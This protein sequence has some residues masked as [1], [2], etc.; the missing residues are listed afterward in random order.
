MQLALPLVGAY[1][2]TMMGLGPG[3]GWAAG[4][5]IYSAYFAP[6]MKSEGPRLDSLKVTISSFGAS[7]PKIFGTLRTG[8]NLIWSSDLVE[9]STTDDVG[10]KGGPSAEVTTYSYFGNFQVLV[11]E[12]PV[13]GIRRIW[14]NDDLI[15]DNRETSTR[16]F[17]VGGD[18]IRVYLGGNTQLADTLIEQYE[19]VGNVPAYRG[20]CTIV[21]DHLPL[22]NYGNGLPQISVEVVGFADGTAGGGSITGDIS[23]A[24]IDYGYDDY[25][26]S[27]DNYIYDTHD[28]Y[29]RK[30]DLLPRT[31]LN[32]ALLSSL[33][34]PI[35]VMSQTLAECRGSIIGSVDL[36]GTHADAPILIGTYAADPYECP[37]Q[38][39]VTV[40]VRLD[41]VT[42]QPSAVGEHTG[43]TGIKHD[44]TVAPDI[45]ETW[46]TSERFV[47]ACTGDVDAGNGLY[48]FDTISG[49]CGILW[50]FPTTDALYA[51][52]V[53]DTTAWCLTQ[54]SGAWYISR[55]TLGGAELRAAL[56]FGLALGG[57]AKNLMVADGQYLYFKTG[58]ILDASTLALV[59]TEP[60]FAGSSLF[61]LDRENYITIIDAG[62]TGDNLVYPLAGR[63]L[64]ATLVSAGATG[65]FSATERRIVAQSTTAGQ[66]VLW[67]VAG[68]PELPISF[69]NL[70][71]NI[72]TDVGLTESDLNLTDTESVLVRGFVCAN[73]Q[74]ARSFLEQVMAIHFIEMVESDG[75]CKFVQRGKTPARTLSYDELGATEGDASG[76]RVAWQNT[77]ELELPRQIE[78][79]YMNRDDEYN[80]GTRIASRQVCSTLERVNVTPPCALTNDEASTIVHRMLE[81]AWMESITGSA[82]VTRDH[83]DLEPTDV[84]VLA[85]AAES[86]TV[87]LRSVSESPGGMIELSFSRYAA[88]LYSRTGTVDDM[89]Y[90]AHGI[91]ELG[92]TWPLVLDIP[93]YGDTDEGC[94]YAGAMDTLGASWY[95]SVFVSRDQVS[96]K[97]GGY[98]LS[99]ATLGYATTEAPDALPCMWDVAGTVGL[100][101]ANSSA[102]LSSKP[103]AAVRAGENLAAF[104]QPGRWEMIRFKT[105]TLNVDGSYT[106]SNIARGEMGTEQHTAAHLAGDRFALINSA[107]VKIPVPH[108]YAGSALTFRF[109]RSGQ[110]FAEGTSV[111]ITYRGEAMKPWPLAWVEG[112]RDGSNNLTVTWTRLSRVGDEMPSGRAIALGEVSEK[113][114]VVIYASDWTTIKRTVAGLSAPTFTYTAAEQTTDFGSPQPAVRIKIYQIS[115]RVGR[116]QPRSATV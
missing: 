10:G 36:I 1:I 48:S 38:G 27:G 55:K 99:P 109:V 73:R 61:L 17:A 6:S 3:V 24:A 70:A 35:Q 54:L 67:G 106:L 42:L 52:A 115:D 15:Y 87:I 8:C 50:E 81:L 108:D 114:D 98:I 47:Y 5:M 83:I 40:L 57:Y 72:A 103:D 41:P 89:V 69:A 13:K 116:G 77:Q 19:G 91:P 96:W 78:L 9:V 63:T 85:D 4:S 16:M 28:S 95:G 45:A 101:L 92:S 110:T 43:D 105:A 33:Y 84:I 97:T 65:Y 113:Y 75:K 107:L 51:A 64:Y 86:H 112:T 31:V 22:A 68:I 2:S 94:V 37:F 32:Q 80:T 53:R 93:Y 44:G 30:L 18:A 76:P 46:S 111:T 34:T 100:K 102:S 14:A 56:P 20:R 26:V 7:I 23:G 88:S 11:C 66:Y 60:K 62:G 90:P 79:Q 21:F 39:Y 12:G 58:H 25:A 29:I 59:E 71:R 82:K 74:A 49:A 104:G